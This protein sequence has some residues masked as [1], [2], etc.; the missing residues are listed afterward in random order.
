[1]KALR[2]PKDKKTFCANGKRFLNF[3]EV[4]TYAAE[5]NMFVSNTQTV[6][7][8]TMCDL[9]AYEKETVLTQAEIVDIYRPL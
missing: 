3:D 2:T 9:T 6:G 8:F 5:R 1:M 4:H 7:V